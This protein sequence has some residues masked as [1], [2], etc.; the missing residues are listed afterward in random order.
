[1]SDKSLI[2]IPK[3]DEKI[4]QLLIKLRPFLAGPRSAHGNRSTI[5]GAFVKVL[6][7]IISFVMSVCL[8]A[9]LPVSPST[10]NNST[11]IGRIFIK[12]YIRVFF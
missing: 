7:A 11:A 1:M 12:F 6:K 8:P 4:T 2:I 5:L 9:Y 10:W 3:C